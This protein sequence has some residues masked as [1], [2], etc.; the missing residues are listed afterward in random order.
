MTQ[1]LPVSSL[2]WVENTSQFSKDLLENN[3]DSDK[4]H[5]L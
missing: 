5:F 2:K 3:E 1:T 4:G